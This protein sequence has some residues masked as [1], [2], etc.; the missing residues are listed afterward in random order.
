MIQYE[1]EILA[2]EAGGETDQAADEE[3]Q[4]GYEEVDEE[5][6]GESLQHTANSTDYS[7]QMGNRTAKISS[8]LDSH[9][10]IPCHESSSVMKVPN[11]QNHKSLFPEDLLE[12]YTSVVQ[13]I[14]NTFAP[15]GVW[16]EKSPTLTLSLFRTRTTGTLDTGAE[17]GCISEAFARTK[18]MF[19]N[20]R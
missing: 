12:Y 4:E 8:I 16:K 3:V 14:Q 13:R 15:D 2:S 19:R 18:K 5:Y 1:D 9:D 20:L 11:S 6:E 17:V 7:F 10:E